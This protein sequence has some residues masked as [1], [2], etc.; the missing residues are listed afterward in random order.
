[1]LFCIIFCVVFSIIE[2][3]RKQV[4][5][6]LKY[7]NVFNKNI[8]QILIFDAIYKIKFDIITKTKDKTKTTL[9]VYWTVAI[10]TGQSISPWFM[11]RDNING[12]I[13]ICM[14]TGPWQYQR[15]NP[16]LNGYWTVIISTHQS[17]SVWLLDCD[18][19]KGS[20]QRYMVIGPSQY[21]RV[22]PYMYG[23]WSVWRNLPSDNT[24][25]VNHLKITF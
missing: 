17:I 20:I 10:S 25:G 16:Y 22:S 14:V 5:C 8:S 15:V 7:F 24:F 3:C 18:N 19:I 11:D 9:Y 13:H 21:K 1:M 4:I 12:S 6:V 23:Y 2:N